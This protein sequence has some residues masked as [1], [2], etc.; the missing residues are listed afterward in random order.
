MNAAT[1]RPL[2]ARS[3]ASVRKDVLLSACSILLLVV[4][5]FP[6]YWILATSLKTEQEIFRIPATL[7]PETLSTASYAAQLETG[8]FNMFHSFA[9][10]LMIS[11]CAMGISVLLAVP[12]S[13]GIA[14]Y[15][16]SG[17][18]G[19][20]MAFLVTQMLPASVLLTPM[21]VAGLEPGLKRVEP[22]R[23]RAVEHSLLVKYRPA[24]KRDGRILPR[25]LAG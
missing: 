17:R 8:D 20:V 9:N 2:A 6:L 15:R 3:A 12:A 14:R 22:L 19:V 1:A 4:L 18:R 24:H 10:S 11:L 16:F 13:Y 23:K 7:W 25:V 21:S 5:L